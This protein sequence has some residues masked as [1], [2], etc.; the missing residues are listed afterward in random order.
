MRL[1]SILISDSKTEGSSGPL[2]HDESQFCRVRQAVRTRRETPRDGYR[3]SSRL[4]TW[5]SAATV[6]SRA[7]AARP[8]R[9]RGAQQ[10]SNRNCC[11]PSESLFRSN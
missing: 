11:V 6:P 4:G 1:D 10:T 2:L 9:H 5:I 3:V 7:P 8:H